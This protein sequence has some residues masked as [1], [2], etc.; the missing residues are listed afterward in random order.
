M[1][2]DEA[3]QPGAEEIVLGQSLE[4]LSIEDL[5]R[6][7]AALEAEIERVREEIARKNKIGAAAAAV[8][9]D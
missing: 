8:F 7:V 9:K 2:W 5:E 4:R 6:R 3:R 1:D